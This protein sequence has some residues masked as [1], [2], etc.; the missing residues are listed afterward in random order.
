MATPSFQTKAQPIIRKYLNQFVKLVHPDLFQQLD[1]PTVKAT[2]HSSLASLNSILST[3]FPNNRDDIGAMQ[4]KRRQVGDSMPLDAVKLEFYC[5]GLGGEIEKLNRVM[6]KLEVWPCLEGKDTRK[7]A[8]TPTTTPKKSLEQDSS[9]VKAILTKSLSP[10]R[11]TEIRESA[12][13]TSFLD[14]C[15]ASGIS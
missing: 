2:N 6:H 15:V 8:S 12:I 5:K 13:A 11:L 14:L 9:Y 10:H 7:N 1:A 4:M 3:C